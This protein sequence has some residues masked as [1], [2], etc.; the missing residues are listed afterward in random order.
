M[1]IYLVQFLYLTFELTWHPEQFFMHVNDL[2]S[3][4]GTGEFL[5]RV[6]ANIPLGTHQSIRWG[7]GRGAWNSRIF[8]SP[9]TLTLFS[10]VSVFDV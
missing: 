5:L 4:D 8:V 6:S 3:T 10:A 2:H 9:Y 1:Y 7:G